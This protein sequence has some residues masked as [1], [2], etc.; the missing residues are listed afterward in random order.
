MSMGPAFSRRDPL[1]RSALGGFPRRVRHAAA[2][3][4]SPARSTMLR[5]LAFISFRSLSDVGA[6]LPQREPANL[7]GSVAPKLGPARRLD[8][9]LT[10]HRRLA[11]CVALCWNRDAAPGPRQVRVASPC[12]AGGVGARDPLLADQPVRVSWLVDPGVRFRR[13]DPAHQG[14]LIRE[15]LACLHEELPFARRELRLDALRGQRPLA[16]RTVS[17]ELRELDRDRHLTASP[18]SPCGA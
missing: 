13:L 10:G 11:A 9:E 6:E 14:N 17:D 4:T 8:H 3:A 2:K 7:R 16:T 1:A 15:K 12:A 5:R 18:A